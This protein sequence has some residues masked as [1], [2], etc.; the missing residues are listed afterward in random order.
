MPQR[1][2]PG[3]A[4]GGSSGCAG[5]AGG[6]TGLEDALPR[7]LSPCRLSPCRLS[8]CRVSP[9][10]SVPTPCVPAPCVPAPLSTRCSNPWRFHKQMLPLAQP[11]QT[12]DGLCS[13][14]P[15]EQ[16]SNSINETLG[17]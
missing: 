1:A 14:S 12:N 16:G 4:G 13:P 10:P 11:L 9:T 15:L 5:A 2:G 6:S 3:R 8:P 17:F 7:R